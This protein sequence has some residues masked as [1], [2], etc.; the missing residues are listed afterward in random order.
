MVKKELRVTNMTDIAKATGTVYRLADVG[1]SGQ[2]PNTVKRV[3]VA[4]D[5]TTEGE[6]AID[7]ALAVAKRLSAHLTL[8]HV[9]HKSSRISERCRLIEPI[10][11]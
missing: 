3:L 1:S 4:T 7:F 6:R 11:A 8:L 10:S 2:F 5:L 9:Y